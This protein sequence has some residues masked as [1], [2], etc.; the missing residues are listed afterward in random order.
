MGKKYIHFSMFG[1][2]HNSA[3]CLQNQ[4]IFLF[5]FGKLANTSNS[6]LFK[7]NPI[8]LQWLQMQSMKTTV[9]SLT[10]FPSLIIS[11]KYFDRFT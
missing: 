6:L 9:Q 11:S 7:L 3:P 8:I 2:V 10:F 1:I 4:P 5:M